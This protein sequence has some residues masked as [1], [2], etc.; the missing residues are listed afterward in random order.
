[1]TRKLILEVFL[2]HTVNDASANQ[3]LLTLVL[4]TLWSTHGAAL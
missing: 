1:M 2:T 4:R 3:H